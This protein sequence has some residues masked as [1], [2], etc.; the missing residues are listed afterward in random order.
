MDRKSTVEKLKETIYKNHY[1]E[2]D[3]SQTILLL[4]DSTLDSAKTIGDLGLKE[5]VSL[6][7]RKADL[8]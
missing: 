1:E 5:N 3:P 4:N 6:V 8:W 2:L 7:Q